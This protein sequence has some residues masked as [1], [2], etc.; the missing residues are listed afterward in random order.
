MEMTK[1]KTLRDSKQEIIQNL[2][3][4]TSWNGQ[5]FTLNIQQGIIP[6]HYKFWHNKERASYLPQNGFDLGQDDFQNFRKKNKI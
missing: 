6:V 2:R 1:N 4:E 5:K 3:E